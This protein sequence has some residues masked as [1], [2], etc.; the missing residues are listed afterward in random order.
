M[1]PDDIENLEYVASLNSKV[2]EKLDVLCYGHFNVIHPGHVRFLK[3]A[4]GQGQKLG[5]LLKSDKDFSSD[6]QSLYFTEEE[7]RS[8]LVGLNLVSKVLSKGSLSFSECVAIIK[9]AVLILGHEAEKDRSP[10]II[11]TERIVKDYGGSVIFHAGDKIDDL[12]LVNQSIQDI[13]SK[14]KRSLQA[15]CQRRN[16]K[17]ERIQNLMEK[18][19]DV[20]I[21]TLGDLIVDE[22]KSCEPLGLSSEAPVVVVRELESSKFTGGAGVVAAHVA[23]LGGKSHLVSVRGDDLIGSEAAKDLDKKGVSHFLA[24]DPSRPTT[25]KTRYIADAQ[26]LFRVS[27]LVDFDI[28][29]DLEDLIIANVVENLGDADGLIVSDFV[30]GVVTERVL[31]E[32]KRQAKTEKLVSFLV[33]YNVAVKLVTCSIYRL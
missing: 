33:I 3:F 7:R 22:F 6:S 28:G 27:K 9:P 24:R 2:L 26:K 18:F 32:I 29:R 23:A 31:A 25:H 14:N 20:K 16:L 5:V 19:S 11:E 4:A 1:K 12:D 10:E 13:D 8:S 30:Y 15:V 17:I 21:V